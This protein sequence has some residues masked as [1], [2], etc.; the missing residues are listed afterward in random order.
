MKVTKEVPMLVRNEQIYIGTSDVLDLKNFQRSEH[1]IDVT[2]F[3]F[4][5]IWGISLAQATI[6]LKYTAHKFLRG[7]VILLDC[8]CRTDRVFTR[9]T[10]QGQ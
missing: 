4:S 2:T 3:Y 10:L 8:R 7:A 5:N 9:K 1:R 6:T